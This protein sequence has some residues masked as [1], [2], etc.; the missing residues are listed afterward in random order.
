[1]FWKEEDG[2]NLIMTHSFKNKFLRNVF[3]LSRE[4]EI[5][6]IYANSKELIEKLKRNQKIIFKGELSKC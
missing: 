1:M 5:S 6:D 2:R 3:T 4:L